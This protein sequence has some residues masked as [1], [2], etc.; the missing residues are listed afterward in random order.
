IPQVIDVVDGREPAADVISIIQDLD[1]RAV[2]CR[3]EAER[4]NLAAGLVGVARLQRGAGLYG[5]VWQVGEGGIDAGQAPGG[6]VSVPGEEGIVAAG[7]VADLL[8]V[9]LPIVGVIDAAS[10]PE[11]VEVHVHRLDPA[12]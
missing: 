1:G 2:G 8:D 7:L 6:A 4:A 5:A 10:G 11:R 12:R 3:A 9:A